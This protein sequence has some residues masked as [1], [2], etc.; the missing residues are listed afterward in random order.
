VDAAIRQTVLDYV[1]GWY[2]GDAVRVERSL[3]PD[4]AK[5]EVRPNDS[6][7]RPWPP[8]DFL[9]EMSAMRLVQLTG[10]QPVPAP[11]PTLTVMLLDRFEHIASVKI[12]GGNDV[13]Y[14]HVARCNGQWVIVNVL[15][16][17]RQGAPGKVDEAAIMR[18]AGDYR[19]G[20]G[21]GDGV[22][23]ER[24]LHPELAKR[25]VGPIHAP[26]PVWPSPSWPPGDKLYH[27][28]GLGLAQ[29]YRPSN[30]PHAHEEGETDVTTLDRVENGASVRVDFAD[31]ADYLHIAKW[32]GQWLIV[33]VLW[34]LRPTAKSF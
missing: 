16:G 11:E 30:P 25:T 7:T 2:E 12:R 19:Y 34:A 28:S 22:R 31:C 9:Y 8:G 13:E 10:H 29:Q 15:W 32:N 14:H 1:E 3:H 33:N 6:P 24:S 5:R 23:L 27:L 17:L 18:T 26:S 4:L 21:T 20:A